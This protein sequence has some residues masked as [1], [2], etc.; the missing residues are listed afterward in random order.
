MGRKNSFSQEESV[1]VS[2]EYSGSTK[3]DSAYLAS[4]AQDPCKWWCVLDIPKVWW[5]EIWWSVAQS[6][7]VKVIHSLLWSLI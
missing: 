7:G 4:G 6:P 5:V 1:E 3:E 2:F